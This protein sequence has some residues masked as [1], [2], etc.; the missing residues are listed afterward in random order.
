MPNLVFKK[1]THEYFLDDILL[2]S[3]TGIL[4]DLGIIDPSYVTADDLSFGTKVHDTTK[5]YD[6]DDLDESSLDP[7]L[8]AYLNG[9]KKFLHDTKFVTQRNQIEIPSYSPKYK[10]GFTLDRNGWIEDKRTVVDIKTSMTPNHLANKLQLA[11]YQSGEN[12]YITSKDKIKRR[13]AVH[14]NVHGTY[15]IWEYRDKKDINS[16]LSCL[17]VFNLK[18]TK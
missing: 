6:F 7:L 18:R 9:W 4:R 14:L 1:D 12:E 2:P 16:W 3:V 17:N 15:K 11:A 10:Y 8:A 13:I 5:L